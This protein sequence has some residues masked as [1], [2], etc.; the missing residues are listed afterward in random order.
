VSASDARERSPREL[1]ERITDRLVRPAFAVWA[2]GATATRAV[3]R[4]PRRFLS[5]CTSAVQSEVFNAVLRERLFE[6]DDVRLGDLAYLH[7]NGAVFV[8]EDLAAERKRVASFEISPSGPLLGPAAAR[9]AGEVAELEDRIAARFGVTAESFALARSFAQKGGRRPLRV[10]LHGA[11]V[12]EEETRGERS[13]W[14]EFEL[15]AG[16]YAT[17]V[18]EELFKRHQISPGPD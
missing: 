10:P 6:I 18:L 15:P 13:L 9:P 8:V 11:S 5:L 1:A 16:S 4:L 3:R 12:R 17:V 14:L 2:G 7:R